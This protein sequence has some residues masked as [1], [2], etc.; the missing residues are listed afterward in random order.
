MILS[1]GIPVVHLKVVPFREYSNCRI[2]LMGAAQIVFGNEGNGTGNIGVAAVAER[3]CYCCIGCGACE[4]VAKVPGVS[5]KVVGTVSSG[6][7]V[8]K[9]NLQ[10]TAAGD[11]IR[12]YFGN[13]FRV[14]G[15]F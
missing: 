5:Q 7:L 4:S 3:M 2:V 13:Q 14:N 8:A 9:H 12:I 1:A 11:N 15:Q 10:W 6:G